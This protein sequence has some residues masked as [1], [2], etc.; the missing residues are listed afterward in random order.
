[1]LKQRIKTFTLFWVISCL[2]IYQ[3]SNASPSQ[4]RPQ[5]QPID[6]PIIIFKDIGYYHN[7]DSYIHFRI[8]VPMRPFLDGINTRIAH[9]IKER[10]HAEGAISTSPFKGIVNHI[11]DSGIKKLNQMEAD[12]LNIIDNLPQQAQISKRF[13]DILGLFLGGTALSMATYNN[14]KISE[15]NSQ[16]SKLQEAHNTLVDITSIHNEHLKEIDIQLQKT[17]DFWREYFTVNPALM[18]T[19]V[20]NYYSEL[21]RVF[22]ILKDTIA[23]AIDRKLSISLLN[24]ETVKAITQQIRK[25][26]TDQEAEV[27]LRQ[28]IDLFHQEVSYL[29]DSKS[30]NLFIIVHIPTIKRNE[31]FKLQQYMPFP[32]LTT[33]VK[34][35]IITTLQDI[36]A[37]NLDSQLLSKTSHQQPMFFATSMGE[38]AACH[39]IGNNFYCKGRD[40]FHFSPDTWCLGALYNRNIKE[41][42]T[43]CTYM[44]EYDREM[45]T[46][47]NQDTW[48]VYSP[49]MI[50]RYAKCETQITGLTFSGFNLIRLPPGCQLDLMEN[51]IRA[52][53]HVSHEIDS[54]MLIDW[55]L[56]A[57][58]DLWN[59][60]QPEV[61]QQ[62]DQ[63]SKNLKG[64][65]TKADQ[66]L[67]TAKLDLAPLHIGAAWTGIIII[68]ILVSLLGMY[69]V[70]KKIKNRPIHSGP[71][72]DHNGL[73]TPAP[74]PFACLRNQLAEMSKACDNPLPNFQHDIQQPSQPHRMPSV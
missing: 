49:T 19:M 50:N 17:E 72:L 28:N 22:H 29:F 2:T 41:V 4:S 51:S 67:K 16:I 21:N 35:I 66:D 69:L 23:S 48:G 74:G 68:F 7:V 8:P 54:V 26:A 56:N 12:F 65:H 44:E 60:N 52:R 32:I 13:I 25:M 34:P 71:P 36:L 43:K 62:L 61:L 58:Q 14:Q 38:L 24:P 70:Y 31:V 57:T 40:V 3:T 15:I 6:K 10:N 46:K 64:F 59:D 33:H 27:P 20:E 37:T 11:Y 9:I 1:M 73:E 30:L 45:V 42:N 18:S 63:Y 47:I 53:S 55:K 39:K 5:V